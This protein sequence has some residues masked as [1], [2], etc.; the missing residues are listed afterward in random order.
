MAEVGPRRQGAWRW[1]LAAAA[2]ASVLPGGATAGPASQTPPAVYVEKGACPTA[3]V[4]PA[5]VHDHGT[6]QRGDA[7]YVLTYPGEGYW[8]VWFRGQTSEE[9]IPF[10]VTPYDRRRQG[11]T[12]AKPSGACWGRAEEPPRSTW[13]IEVRTAGGQTGWTNAG[14]HFE[15]GDACG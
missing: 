5:C 11:P 3:G 14:A 7:L 15:G 10:L 1:L 12:C 9:E 6:Y 4:S 8:T 2:V 13:W